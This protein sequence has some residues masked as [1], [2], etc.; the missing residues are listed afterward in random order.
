MNFT[1]PG[2]SLFRA[3]KPIQRPAA[4]AALPTPNDP[5]V[6]AAADAV[7]SAAATRKG[8]LSTNKTATLG[9]EDT[10]AKT[11]RRTLVGVAA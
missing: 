8:L 11:K 4:P 3:P 10:D 5:S 2:K 6:K 9:L 7:R 1:L